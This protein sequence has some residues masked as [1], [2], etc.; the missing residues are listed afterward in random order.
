MNLYEDFPFLSVGEA[1]AHQGLVPG[2]VAMP[3]ITQIPPAQM[4]PAPGVPVQI[5]CENCL[6]FSFFSF[7]LRTPRVLICLAMMVS[8]VPAGV[9]SNDW[10]R[11]LWFFL[12]L[13][14]FAQGILLAMEPVA[15]MLLAEGVAS[16]PWT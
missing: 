10:E 12:I 5:W 3:H 9:I 1:F 14:F 2:P 15:F 11:F 13:F 7:W 16:H 8:C 6:F 4:L